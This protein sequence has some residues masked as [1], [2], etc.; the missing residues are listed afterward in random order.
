MTDTL[1][2]RCP[3]C[4]ASNRVPLAKIAEGLQPVCGQCK[5]PLPV[6]KPLDV[7]EATFATEVEQSPLPV[8]LDVWAA[9]C[10]P[11]RTI[12][13]MIDALAKQLVGRVRFAKLNVDENPATASR[14]NIHSIPT[15]LL[16]KTGHEVDRIVGVASKS[17]ITRRLEQ[18]TA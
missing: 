15:L 1:L 18:L 9:W 8:L 11:C 13:P 6:D 12:A 16:F 3:A 5:A 4:G 17:E 2:I 10:G 14:L 7:T